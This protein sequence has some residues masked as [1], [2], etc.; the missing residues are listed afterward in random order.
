MIESNTSVQTK[1]E[2]ARAR[3]GLVEKRLRNA[4][5]TPVTAASIPRRPV[6]PSA[7]LSFAQQRL[8]FIDQLE[9]G[10][11]AY[12]IATSLR[13]SGNLNV[14]A[15]ERAIQIIIDRHEVLR[16]RFPAVDGSPI[17][18]IEPTLRI[19][20]PLVDLTQLP[21]AE[22]EQRTRERFK[23]AAQE[24][25]NLATGPLI[26]CLL[27]RKSEQ[28]HALL[29]VMHHI[30][31][32]GWSLG[33]LFRELSLAYQS[34][35]R[36][37][38]AQL[39]E[40][41]IQY[42]DYAQWQHQTAA[43]FD[44]H[45]RW[46]KSKLEH[47]PASL[48][49]PTDEQ[50]HDQR[51]LL[52][53]AAQSIVIPESLSKQLAATSRSHSATPFM[54]LLSTLLITM[55][56]WSRQPD[57]VLG[58]VVAGRTCR[59]VENLIGCFMNFLPV[60]VR[61]KGNETGL[62]VLEQVKTAVL[63][64]HAHQDCPFDKIVEA[65]NP[66]RR[67]NQ[68]PLYNVGF[69]LQ[70]YPRNVFEADA[71]SGSMQ[72]VRT[73]TALLDLRFIA[74]E[75]GPEISLHC[76]YDIGLFRPQTIE[77]LLDS[78]RSL[79]E[80]LANE[81]ASPIAAFELAPGLQQ[82]I[83]ASDKSKQTQTIAI[84]GT[85]TCEP[86]AD[87]L[88]F[89]MEKLELRVV[90]RFAPYN[91][92]FQQLLDPASLFA[93][94]R[95]GLNVLLVRI[96]DWLRSLPPPA[97]ST[98]PE[99]QEH[100]AQ[101]VSEF[102]EGI[103]SASTR[104]G[105]AFLVCFCPQSVTAKSEAALGHLLDAAE[106]R[107]IIAL[108]AIPGV[109]LVPASELLRVY[110]LTEY[111]DPQG[112]RLGHVPYTPAFF[113]ALGTMIARKFH[114][115]KRPPRK[116]IALDCD[117]T[118]WS[119]ICGEDGP[120]GVKIDEPRRILH[121]FMHAQL[122]AGM[123]LCL[124]SKNNPEDVEEVFRLHQMPLKREDFAACRLNWVPKSENLRSLAQELNLGLDSFIFIDDNP[125]ECAEVEANCPGV[126]AVQL[127]ED[128]ASMERFLGHLWILDHLKVTEE[129][130]K[131]TALY[132]QNRQREQFQAQ[133]LSFA[134]FLA[135]LNLQIQIEEPAPAQLP[136]V[137]Q[138]T[139]RTN[140]FNFS[141]RRRTEGEI[142][143]LHQE[144]KSQILSI[145]VTDRFGDY[146][147]VG[148][149]I[150]QLT[151]TA[152]DVDTFL[153]S[154]RVLGKGVEHRILSRLGEIAHNSGRKWVDLHFIHS[155]KNKPA[156]DFLERIGASFRHGSN[157]STL[158]RFP[159]DFAAGIAFTPDLPRSSSAAAGLPRMAGILTLS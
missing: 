151:R 53:G 56:R 131:R 88:Q 92:I 84:A 122:D 97:A 139:E 12:H 17:Q 156:F 120:A 142:V 9:P 41:R 43:N 25:F 105:S 20:L 52:R 143:K 91:Q 16:T 51:S 128:L 31:S 73:D 101:T 158:F 38:P 118:L 78:F 33:L 155:Q 7:P 61:L 74:E 48:N 115:L 134:D 14:H 85:F 117:N 21:E 57:L 104:I 35:T 87:S 157:G 146:G 125:I 36:Q 13:L 22:R 114:A 159:A 32:D 80:K 147:L 144:K 76:E 24:A 29:V 75:S 86:L 149:V 3:Q 58:T 44:E 66:N 109:H 150:Y 121:E 2:L 81:P 4:L 112:E 99:V 126:I 63:E 93:S 8:W 127:P 153:L 55:H 94:N 49:L 19:E 90:S 100:L 148:V 65:V 27:V 82:Q 26:R 108:S 107:L 69:L 39:P 141:T 113:T 34:I 83:E 140:Q 68:N 130:R 110:P 124:C 46:W 11:P 70:N 116:V 54:M 64:A 135:G 154:C 59:E 28:E 42:A 45:V 129:D 79:L 95:N 103:R 72:T 23:E 136:R 138:L 60:R 47:A 133:A 106:N 50:R 10:S 40:L 1:P 111:D 96:E 123:L 132:L 37:Q 71:I 62:E 98:R 15:L 5:K 89:W 137:A 18:L 77:Y 30:I 67:L 145:T 6:A 152:L 102:V 119:G